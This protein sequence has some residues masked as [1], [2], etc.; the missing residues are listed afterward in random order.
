M[1]KVQRYALRITG[2][3]IAAV[4]LLWTIA[5]AVITMKK[6]SINELAVKQVN[7]QVHGDVVIGD[8]TP[9]FFRM[10][11]HI[12]VR[13]SDVSIRDSL[14]SAHEHDFLSAERI[15]I[16]LQFWSL[17]SGKPRIGK[18]VVENASIHLFTDECGY[19]NLNRV[20]DLSFNKGSEEADIPE[21][22]FKNTRLIVENHSLN[23]FHDIE[24]IYM[25]CNV[26][27]KD[28]AYKLDIIM[29]TKMHSLGFNMFKGSFLKEKSVKGNFH[30]MYEPG[31]KIS[32]PEIVL[33]IDEHPFTIKGDV[34]FVTDPMSYK[35]N[36]ATEAVNYKLGVSLLTQALQQKLDSLDI[37]K[38]I[39]ASVDLEGQMAYKAQPKVFVQF[40]VDDAEMDTPVGFLSHST[41]NGTFDNEVDSLI[42]RGDVNSRITFNNLYAEFSGMPVTSSLIEIDNLK[43]PFLKCHIQ[44]I[45]ELNSLNE[46][47]ESTTINFLKGKGILDV[48]YNGSLSGNDTIYPSV[49]GT[50][51]LTDAEVNYIPRNLVFQ[52]CNGNLEFKDEDLI[53][54][55]LSAKAGNTDLVMSG[56]I[57]HLLALL[58]NDLDRLVME[59]NITTPDLNLN[60][61][62]AYV[63]P[64]T[65]VTVK[66][67]TSKNKMI[68]AAENI[69]RLLHDG[70]AKL[71]IN[72]GR[73]IYK[74]FE[75]TNVAA[76]VM[77]VENK[78]LFNDV[79]LQ[80]AGGSLTMNGSLINGNNSNQLVLNSSIDN[81]NIP[82]IFK[83]FDN[84][85]QDA[86]T[87]N[88]MKGRMSAKI[89][90][91]GTLTDKATVAE[92]T[93]NGTV[94]FSIK[95]GEL[96]NFEPA[97]KIAA[98]AFK[99]R[100]FSNI[101]F[102]ELKNRLDIKGSEIGIEKMEIRSN[103]VVLFVEGIYDTKKGTD[104]SI[105]VPV[106]NL[107]KAE[108]D[109]INTGKVGVNV[110]LR[111]KTGEDGKL[112]ITWDPFNKA[113]KE[114]KDEIAQDAKPASGK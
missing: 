72:A 12:S 24:A 108:N 22:T 113:S 52:N 35:L 87:Y 37:K 34:F 65:T 62:L 67:S 89:N 85:G 88:N 109:I 81:V 47:T 31:Q 36:I 77:L 82:T 7:K 20:E 16:R 4:L 83:A 101:Q 38:P 59:W 39:N 3:L 55:N 8:L 15:F 26:S 79:K 44:S 102:G 94:N 19:C 100:D 14:W 68:R 98:T 103:V 84:F 97:V 90:M 30:L 60:D 28:S 91:T 17:L 64:R 54:N 99:K 95:N 71:N 78:V 96:N 76:S 5:F 110:R 11:P 73:L 27:K 92:N 66:K 114:R 93:M 10:F 2:G 106:S 46:L 29:N 6:D 13:L 75:A 112:N 25:D 21:L 63:K 40:N 105:Q 104:M 43:D 61:F 58:D 53:I 70:T 86:V 1:T 45:F 41:F 57:L 33:D 56:H 48:K 69:D 74:N 9:N 107:S 42:P 49:N 50:L 51:S 80:H 32:I 18:V 111:A 23:S